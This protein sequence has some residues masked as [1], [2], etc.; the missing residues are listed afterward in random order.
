MTEREREPSFAQ[1]GGVLSRLPVRVPPGPVEARKLLFGALMSAATRRRPADWIVDHQPLA[2]RVSRAGGGSGG[3]TV[4]VRDVA[5]A[6]SRLAAV[7]HTRGVAAGD[8]CVVWLE[9]PLDVMLAVTA[10]TGIGA[11]PVTL[12]PKLDP[13]L[14]AAALEPVR[15]EITLLAGQRV[16]EAADLRGIPVTR[17][18]LWEE[19]AAAAA[20]G[21]LHS[22]AIPPA[23]IARGAADPYVVT[24]TSGTTGIPKLTIHTVRSFFEQADMQRK[25]IAL[26][27]LRGHLA[28][29]VSPVHIRTL[30][31]YLGLL[32][33]G[34]PISPIVCQAEDPESTGR[35]LR[36]WRP[37]Y[38][39]THPNTFVLWEELADAG[40]ME[41][42][43]VF[44]ATFDAT[45]PR[46]VERLLAGSRRRVPMFVELY[47]QSECG[48]LANRIWLGGK[49]RAS[50]PLPAVT[51]G[52]ALGW[53]VPGYSQIRIADHS[54][55]DPG[56][57][58]PG[59]ILA[60]SRGRFGG[61]L[62]MPGLFEKNLSADGW[63]DTG[64]YGM[65]DRARQLHLLDRQV[66]RLSRASSAVALE[67]ILL[68][69]FPALAEA[70]VMELDGRL[71]P[72]VASRASAPIDGGA[73]AAAVKDLPELSPPVLLSWADI[74]RTATGKVRRAILREQLARLS[75]A[76]ERS[77]R[78]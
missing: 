68:R 35:M 36:T 47:A 69:R 46:T 27:R 5:A 12:S 55:A 41:S 78:G 26:M 11:I 37:N 48:P 63:W 66:E 14:A 38:L 67:D 44:L 9:E 50:R 64:D 49:R 33:S 57:S 77:P 6:A 73:W 4:S 53:A 1:I 24:H 34:A 58:R 62:N 3:G 18:L 10:L 56:H 16:A 42:V 72:V 13:A 2:V 15:R 30:S 22:P 61:Y 76:A 17:R 23:G 19:V 71:I 43:R 70:V 32:L 51:S 60:R 8:W 28:I 59:R 39:E 52:H 54:G 75:P 40:A 20:K 65:V 74:P 31:G 29:A 21:P 25:V 45:H 7:L